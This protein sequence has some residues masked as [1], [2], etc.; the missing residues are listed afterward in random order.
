MSSAPDRRSYVSSLRARGRFCGRAAAFLAVFFL[1][2]PLMAQDKDGLP[3]PGGGREV[4]PEMKKI[5]P[6]LERASGRTKDQLL[7]LF[8][9][10]EPAKAQEPATKKQVKEL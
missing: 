1:A 5:C 8:F 10:L 6:E 2:T 4:T 3:D 9:D 7:A